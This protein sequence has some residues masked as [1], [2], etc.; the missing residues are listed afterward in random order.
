MHDVY[1]IN[2]IQVTDS[3]KWAG[4]VTCTG[5]SRNAYSIVVEKPEGR[6]LGIAGTDEW[7]V[8]KWILKKHDGRVWSGLIWFRI[9]TSGRLLRTK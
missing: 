7:I 3:R 4:H 5:Y 9:W 2:I 8:S 1:N 6:P